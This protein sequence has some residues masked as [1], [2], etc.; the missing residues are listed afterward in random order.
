MDKSYIFRPVWDI[1]LRALHWWNAVTL[2]VQVTLGAVITSF[3]KETPETFEETFL[4]LHTVFGYLFAAGLFTRILWLFVGPPSAR[5][6][7]LLP[8]TKGQRRVFWET[9]RFYAGFFKGAPPLYRG[10]NPFAGVIYAAFFV[11]AAVQVALGSALLTMT[12]KERDGSVFLEIHEFFYFFI[13]LYIFAHVFAIV[14]HELTERKG[15]IS[16]MVHG[17]K[18][19]TE[20]ELEEIEKTERA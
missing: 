4:T 14:V 11:A 9:L 7:D 17:E 1:L 3:T 15:L 5:W 20:E 19:F 2:L 6:Q 16:A 12:E 8:V 13:I 18:S 10:H